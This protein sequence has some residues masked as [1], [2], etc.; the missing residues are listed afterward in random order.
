MSDPGPSPSPEQAAAGPSTF[1]AS[2]ALKQRAGGIVV[3]ILTVILAFVM[4]GVVVAATQ[5]SVHKALLA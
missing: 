1:A 2:L 5:H 3:P 4:G